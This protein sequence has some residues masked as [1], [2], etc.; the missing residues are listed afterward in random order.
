MSMCKDI[1]LRNMT[2]IYISRGTELLMLYRIG[3]RV[4]EPSW[5]GIGGHFEEPELND[6]RSCMLRELE[7]EIGLKE[8]ALENLK[9][10]YVT[11]RLKN[12]EIRQNYYY[13]ADLKPGAEV[14]L[15]S[16]E[17]RVEW[18]SFDQVLDL[19]MPLTA[20]FMLTHYMSTGRFT[21]ALYSGTTTETEMVFAELKEF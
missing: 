19:K 21:D 6:P 10:R 7:E 11:L 16:D 3:S 8:S 2:G 13:F 12:G 4:V 1:N 14:N 9:L 20:K 5:C 15:T 17:G 18:I